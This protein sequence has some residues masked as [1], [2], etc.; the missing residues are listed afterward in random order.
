[1]ISIQYIFKIIFGVCLFSQFFIEVKSFRPCNRFLV[2]I[3]RNTPSIKPLFEA[4]LGFEGELGTGVTFKGK[5]SNQKKGDNR[6]F[7]PF[8]IWEEKRELLIGTFLLEPTTGCGDY[9]DLGEKGVYKVIRVAFLYKYDH[10][11]YNVFQKRL[12][13]AAVNA[14]WK[15]STDDSINFL[16]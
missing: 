13:V 1:M 12:D 8:L 11:R 14:P 15:D 7:L 6:D 5:L 2:N 10:G 9:L 16:Q 4:F 3:P